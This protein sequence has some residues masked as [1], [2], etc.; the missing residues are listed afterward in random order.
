MNAN[1]VCLNCGGSVFV[2]DRSLAGKIVCSKCGSS[3][4]RNKSYS[5]L[6]RKKLIL[7]VIVIAIF[8]III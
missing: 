8:V 4:F 6:N 1:R 2:S 3:S 7:L 5:F